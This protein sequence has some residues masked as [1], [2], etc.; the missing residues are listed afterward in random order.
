M[1]PFIG[2][3]WLPGMSAKVIEE[4]HNEN[5][6]AGTDPDAYITT[7]FLVQGADIVALIGRK[8]QIWK[9]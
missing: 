5:E 9:P 8:K 4:T 2:K 1:P 7:P 6:L 3:Q